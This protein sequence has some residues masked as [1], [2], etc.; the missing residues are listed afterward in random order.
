MKPEGRKLSFSP[1]IHISKSATSLSATHDPD[2]L[3]FDDP[4]IG[5]PELSCL[6]GHSGLKRLIFH[7]STGFPDD[8]TFHG[9]GYI[10]DPGA[11]QVPFVA[12]SKSFNRVAWSAVGS[13]I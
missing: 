7:Y 5:L 4:C 2:P 11:L 1:P 9:G 8:F 10:P 6:D 13:V 3:S 12:A